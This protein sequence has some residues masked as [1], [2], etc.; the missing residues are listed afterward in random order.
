MITRASIVVALLICAAL[1]G[2]R[3]AATERAVDSEPLAKLPLE[4]EGWTGREARP[5]GDD[6]VALLGVDDYIH[7]SYFKPSGAPINLYAGYYRSQRQ[8]DTIHSPQNCLPGAGWRPVESSTVTLRAA[9]RDVTVNQYLIQKGLDQQVVFYW[10]QGRG[11]VVAN[12]YANKALLM[13]DA[14]RLHRTNGGLVRVMTAVTPG[15]DAAR[16]VTAFVSALMP[17]LQRLMP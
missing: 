4:I 6:V 7:R 5:L 14:A 2:G 8:G 12:E 9:G 15:R 3:A 10:Y 1:L 13:W 17:S 16:D 11:R